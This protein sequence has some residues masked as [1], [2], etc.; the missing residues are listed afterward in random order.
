MIDTTGFTAQGVLNP[1]K[2]KNTG[3]YMVDARP[4]LPGGPRFDH[5]IT[6]DLRKTSG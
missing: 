4:S 6:E 5:R 1:T 2:V 3:P